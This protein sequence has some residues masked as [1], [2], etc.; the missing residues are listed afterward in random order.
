VKIGVNSKVGHRW[1]TPKRQG[2]LTFC[3]RCGLVR[4]KNE[5]SARAVAAGCFE[6]DE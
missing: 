1:W 2:W 5:L 4:L 6:D 3:W